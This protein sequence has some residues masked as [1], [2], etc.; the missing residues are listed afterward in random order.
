LNATRALLVTL[1]GNRA[2]IVMVALVWPP[3]EARLLLVLPTTAL[4]CAPPR[5]A[6]HDNARKVYWFGY[7]VLEVW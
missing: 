5:K 3:P 2:Y 4:M 7:S 6:V 1:R